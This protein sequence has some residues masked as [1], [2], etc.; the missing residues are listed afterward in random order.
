MI[1]ALLLSCAE[2]ADSGGEA[3]VD[4]GPIQGLFTFVVFADPHVTADDDHAE[5]LRAAVVWV[6]ENAV[7]ENI[8]LV[9]IVGDIGWGEIGVDLSFELLSEL[10]VP[11]VPVMGDN[12]VQYGSEEAFDQVFSAQYDVLAATQAGFARAATPVANPQRGGQSW[13]QDFS[14]DYAGLHL[15]GL[16][17]N[18]RII[19]TLEGEMADLHDFEGGSWEWFASDLE[20][21]GEGPDDSVVLFSH[22]PMH[23]SPGAFDLAEIELLDGLLSTYDDAVYANFAGHYHVSGDEVETERPL[24]IYVTDAIWDDTNTIRVVRVAGNAAVT[25]YEH[26]LVE[27]P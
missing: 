27:I 3:V 5:R 2:T 21:H 23:L 4:P 7:A 24:D 17:W 12:E 20:Q 25:E 11:W 26:E 14:F 16:D 10:A 13:F 22:H 1:T 18:A 19:G 8:E 6:N 15:V 9:F